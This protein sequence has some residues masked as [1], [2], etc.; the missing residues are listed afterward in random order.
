MKKIERSKIELLAL[1]DY[2]YKAW[3]EDIAFY[4]Y[5]KGDKE[6]NFKN[7]SKKLS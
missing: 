5:I 7:I 2:K 6:F 3:L 1:R 4:D